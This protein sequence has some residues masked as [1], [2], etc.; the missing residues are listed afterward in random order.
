[1]VVKWFRDGKFLG[2]SDKYQMVV[3][4]I[5]YKLVIIDVDGE[6]EGDYSI[7]VRGKKLEGEFIVE[8]NFFV[9]K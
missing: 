3:D 4:G 9:D 5:V 8:G 1:M 2:E 6:D 7:V